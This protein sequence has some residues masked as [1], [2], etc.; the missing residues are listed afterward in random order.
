MNHDEY[1]LIS[2]EIKELETLL[3]GI[4]DENVIERSSLE[5]R[6][7]SARILISNVMERHLARKARLTFRG[8]PVLGSYGI[9][10]D[11]AAKAAG[12]FSDAVAAIAASINESLKYMGPIADRGKSQLLITGTAVGSFGFEF[13]LPEPENNELFPE[14]SLAENALE[15]MQELLYLSAQ[16]SDDEVT[17]LVELIHPRAVKKVEEFL[18]FL[19]Q[20]NAWCGLEFKDEYFRFSN[21]AQL[22]N[23]SERLK[24]KNI[25]DKMIEIRGEFQGVLPKSRAFEFKLAGT[26]EILRGSIGPEVEDPDLINREWLHKPITTSLHMTRVGQARPRYLLETSQDI[27]LPGDGHIDGE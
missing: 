15:R 10:A 26:N 9:A 21:L 23:S 4:P 18:D 22:Q 27:A 7:N 2:S 1:V 11:F 8:Q 25:T 20:R 19:V 6:L 16:G 5:S 17:E 3:S 24:E 13:E 14:S 12:A